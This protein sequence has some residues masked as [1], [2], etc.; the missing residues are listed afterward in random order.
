MAAPPPPESGPDLVE[1]RWGPLSAADRDFLVKVRLAGLWEIPVG[2]QVSE[3]ATQARTKE[4]FGHIAGQHGSLDA[5]VRG[6]A[7]KLRIPLPDQPS[8]QQQQW[9]DEISTE[10]AETYGAIAVKRLRMAHGKIFPVIFE[11]RASTRNT[12]VRDFAERAAKFV[13][14][15]M[16]LLEDT[17]LAD[18]GTLP[19]PP[20]V[21]AAPTPLP[22]DEPA[23]TA[24]PATALIS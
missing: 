4:N 23:P 5:D 6:V 22:E 2:H 15:H 8:E 24:P 20:Q 1:T 17:G 9:I 3:R 12:L 10:P 13:N 14:T 7:A 19:P 18:A 21:T 11:I 16:D